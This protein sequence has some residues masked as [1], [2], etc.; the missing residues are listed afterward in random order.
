MD[1]EPV[2]TERSIQLTTLVHRRQ[3]ELAQLHV[4]M[5]RT[6][7]LAEQMQVQRR[8][9]ASENVYQRCVSSL[10]WPH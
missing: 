4:E 5:S 7:S 3:V 6:S 10:L 8:M 9:D 2:S 1:I